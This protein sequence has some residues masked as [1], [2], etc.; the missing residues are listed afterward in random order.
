MNILF[1]TKPTNGLVGHTPTFYPIPIG[2]L[3]ECK[4]VGLYGDEKLSGLVHVNNDAISGYL[5]VAQAAI[6]GAEA[7]FN[8]ELA[9]TPPELDGPSKRWVIVSSKASANWKLSD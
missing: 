4:E 3:V 6:S 7:V 2:N 1:T 8:F 9:E 5:A